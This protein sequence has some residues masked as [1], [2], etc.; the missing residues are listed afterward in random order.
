MNRAQIETVSNLA[1]EVVG[2]CKLALDRIDRERQEYAE[3]RGCE[4]EPKHPY[5]HSHGSRET[6][7]L[8]RRSMDLTR[9]L[10]DLRR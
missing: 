9:A 2:L 1:A 7:A 10:A 6:G 3:W 8:R 4:I 5:D